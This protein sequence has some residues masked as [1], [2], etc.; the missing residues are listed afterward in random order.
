VGDSYFLGNGWIK[1][2]SN[3]E[4]ASYAVNWLL[5]RSQLL[6]GIGPR[7]MKEFRL[8][9]T[10]S[11]S[12]TVHWLLLGALPGSVLLVGVLVWLRRRN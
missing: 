11:E 6:E 10:Q 9:L 5:D 3:A 4:F 7:P 2:E 12:R 1:M 8:S